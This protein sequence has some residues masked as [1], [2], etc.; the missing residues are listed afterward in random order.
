MA[1]PLDLITL[2]EAAEILGV[3]YTYLSRKRGSLG[4]KEVKRVGNS[5]LYYRF[6]VEEYHLA[7][8]RTLSG[9]PQ[10]R[11]LPWDKQGIARALGLNFDSYRKLRKQ[12]KHYLAKHHRTQ[13]PYVYRYNPMEV[14]KWAHIYGYH[15]D[16]CNGFP[17][18]TRGLWA[19]LLQPTAEPGEGW[20]QDLVL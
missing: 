6:A 20:T 10:L 14:K 13:N 16:L 17:Q 2:K 7:Y 5:L 11:W 1:D 3:S 18:Q 8:S 12:P 19:Q 4:L 9:K 15:L